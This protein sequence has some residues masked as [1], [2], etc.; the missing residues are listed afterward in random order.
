VSERIVD[1]DAARAARVAQQDDAPQL[2]FAGKLF[3]LPRELPWALAE[4]AGSGST[5][6]AVGAIKHLLGDQWAAFEACGPTIDDVRVMLESVVALY[7]A[8]P[9]K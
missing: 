8:D 3:E 7:G 4:A 9:G 6:A 1:L 5:E 2:R